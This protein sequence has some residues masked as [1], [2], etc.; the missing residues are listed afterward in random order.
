MYLYIYICN[1]SCYCKIN[2]PAPFGLF[3]DNKSAFFAI[4]L[5][6]QSTCFVK[7]KQIG[8]FGYL[9]CFKLYKLDIFGHRPIYGLFPAECQSLRQTFQRLRLQYYLRNIFT[10]FAVGLS[11]QKLSKFPKK[12][13]TFS[14]LPSILGHLSLWKRDRK[15]QLA[16]H[17]KKNLQ[18]YARAWVNKDFVH[19]GS[20]GLIKGKHARCV[21]IYSVKRAEA[22][23]IAFFLSP[24]IL[25]I[26]SRSFSTW[27]PQGPKFMNVNPMSIGHL[28]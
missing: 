23:Q 26:P 2:F 1:L 15:K 5:T 4:E 28:H 9:F 24:A 3:G 13:R 7:D 27:A 16:H 25:L 10:A 21:I 19:S 17:H 18:I 8:Y 22:A 20:I 6:L 11:G 14:S 12:C